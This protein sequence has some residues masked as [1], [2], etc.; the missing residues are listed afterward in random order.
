MG[1]SHGLTRGGKF[2]AEYRAWM[3]M[4]HR[5]YAPTYHRYDRYG[6]RGIGVCELWR[7]SAVAFISD[8]GPKPS[9]KHSLDRINN[10]GNY[11][12][13]NCRWATKSEQIANS[14]KAR[15]LDVFGNIMCVTA[16][17]ATFGI[18]ESTLRQRLNRGW[19]LERALKQPVRRWPPQMTKD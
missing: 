15:N 7:S 8:M 12:P 14:S 13:E 16:A 3:K 10:D 2:S 19:T 9:P 4:L 18:K 5:C 11:E 1:M 17:A 6:G